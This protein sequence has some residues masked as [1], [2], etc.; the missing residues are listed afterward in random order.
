MNQRLRTILI[1]A[2]LMAAVG[3]YVVYRL[4]GNQINESARNRGTV[5]VV[6]AGDL[7]IGAVIKPEDLRTAS[8]VGAP[9]KDAFLKPELAV[10]RGVLTPIY[11]GEPVIEK[12]LAPM[13]SG[14]GLA[15]TIP[16]G[17]RACAVKVDEVVGV[18][19][20]VVPGMHVDVVISGTMPGPQDASGTKVR[21]LLQN[22]EV[23][24]AGKNFQR[25][26]QG[27]PVEV[28]VVNL[29][30]TPDQAESLSLAS[31]QTHIQLILRNPIDRQLSHPPGS[32]LANILGH[33]AAPEPKPV[34]RRVI[35]PA[36][37]VR[38]E[39][40]PPI[41]AAPAPPPPPFLVQVINGAKMTE[42]RFAAN[43]ESR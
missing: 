36:P 3:S 27:Q 1:A 6:A 16:P 34:I 19:G 39:P 38:P 8:L 26:N 22:I 9:P 17:M 40:A 21:T 29:L 15:A 43:G 35:V 28:P 23:L 12:R 31:N 33:P 20:F 5:I 32:D 14:G 42:Q 11:A 18:A 13:G 7:G 4:V 41:V 30:V 37:P 10:G 24:S 25:D 2:F